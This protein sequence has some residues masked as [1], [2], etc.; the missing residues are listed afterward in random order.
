M[1]RPCAPQASVCGVTVHK[2]DV[3]NEEA[4]LALKSSLKGEL[5]CLLHLAGA[6]ADGM[7]P[8][9]TG[10]MFQQSYG[11]KARALAACGVCTFCLLYAVLGGFDG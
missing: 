11:P 8:N 4:V 10:E 1:L 5:S 2:C 6:L 3:S 9:L 7:L